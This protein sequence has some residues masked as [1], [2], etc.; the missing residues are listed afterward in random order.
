MFTNG[1]AGN[2][3]MS[4]KAL[5]EAASPGLRCW[6]DKDEDATAEGMRRG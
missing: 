5:L 1:N 4:L 2:T 6:L 3:V